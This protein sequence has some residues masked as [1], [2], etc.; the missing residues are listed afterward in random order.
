MAELKTGR[1]LFPAVDENELIEFFVMVIGMPPPEM[2]E[3][4]K[5]RSKFFKDNQIIRSKIS[6]L[7]DSYERSYPLR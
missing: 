1:P 5:K 2:I 6:R 7:K 3:K 4:A